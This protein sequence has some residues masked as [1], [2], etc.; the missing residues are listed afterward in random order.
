MKNTY[1]QKKYVKCLTSATKPSFV[2]TM[3]EKSKVL[4]QKEVTEDICFQTS[5]EDVSLM[6][7]H[8][9]SFIMFVL[10]PFCCIN[11]LCVPS[12]YRKYQ[13][14]S[15]NFYSAIHFKLKTLP[16]ILK[17]NITNGNIQCDQILQNLNQLWQNLK[18]SAI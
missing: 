9:I 2:G 18:P 16:N 1:A 3:K 14:S 11:I 8:K 6:L 7:K 10:W 17:Q 15:T 12:F 13:N 5:Q 4:E